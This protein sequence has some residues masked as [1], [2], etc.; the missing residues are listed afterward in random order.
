MP[1]HPASA[2]WNEL[3]NRFAAASGWQVRA[4]P[5]AV[6]FRDWLR[7]RSSSLHETDRTDGGDA[8]TRRDPKMA[9]LEAVLLIAEGALSTRRL[10]Q[11]ATL[12]DAAE[13]GRLIEA[14]NH[15]YDAVD[16]AFRVERVATGYQLLT[17]PRFARW[18]DK[19]HQR[20]SQL[21]LSPP[22]LETLTIVAYRQPVTRADVEEIRG[23][24]CTEMLKQLMDRKLV[25][26][27]GHDD[28]LGRPYLY[29]TTRTFLELFGLRNLNDLP[30]AERLRQQKPAPPAEQDEAGESGETATASLEEET[31]GEDEPGDE[32]EAADAA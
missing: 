17:R 16:S 7:R 19:L 3:V 21:K 26:I 12:V 23:V 28:S 24:Q 25:R 11:L 31:L 4:I 10:A 8:P 15:A 20:Q 22:A 27:A 32:D 2:D 14:L 30:M 5:S 6:G 13:A 18:L 1:L 29:G 9:R